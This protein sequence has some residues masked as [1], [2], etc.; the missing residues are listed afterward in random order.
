MGKNGRL[1]TVNHPFFFLSRIDEWHELK[2]LKEQKNNKEKEDDPTVK[3]L[4]D[5]PCVDLLPDNN[6]VRKDSQE[7]AEMN[8]VTVDENIRRDSQEETGNEERNQSTSSFDSQLTPLKKSNLELME[9]QKIPPPPCNKN[10]GKRKISVCSANDSEEDPFVTSH[11]I[12][13]DDTATNFKSKST[14]DLYDKTSASRK[15]FKNGV[16]FSTDKKVISGNGI[17]ETIPLM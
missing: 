6:N 17:S 5:S 9:M 1:R 13:Y 2:W 15:L 16:A 4:E 7:E 10:A 12:G 14:N 11:A 8:S 3:L